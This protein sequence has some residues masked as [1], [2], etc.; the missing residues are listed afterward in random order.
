MIIDDNIVITGSFN[1][2][3][4]TD[5]HNAENILLLANQDVDQVYYQNWLLKK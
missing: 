2:T 5:K 4:N 3:V 1:F